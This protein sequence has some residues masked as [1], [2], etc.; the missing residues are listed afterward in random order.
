MKL[1][2]EV[3]NT[4]L[5]RENGLQKAEVESVRTSDGYP[6]SDY[7]ELVERVAEISFQNPEYVIFYRGQEDDFSEDSEGTTLYP[8]LFRAND[9]HLPRTE[10][11][12]RFEQLSEAEQ[13]LAE[14][15]LDRFS[16][17]RRV[18]TY[19]V[20]RRAIL[21]HYEVC[22]TSF[23]DVTR[24]L[25]V[26]CSMAYRD[27][28]TESAYVYLLGM[29]QVSGSISASSEHGVQVIRLLSVCPPEALRP[30]YQDGYVVG[31]FPTLGYREKLEYDRTEVDLSRR[32][33]GKFR[34]PGSDSFWDNDFNSIPE[35]YLFPNDRDDFFQFVS[36]ID[37]RVEDA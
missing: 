9:N 24:S 13:I 34:L 29:P 33:L 27:N 31:D 18:K 30:H 17:T 37:F 4:F 26:A 8:K 6:V 21:Q 23:L 28:D 15:Y 3:V 35:R 5:D 12:R 10:L 1:I 14:R 7:R 36:R 20:L 25:R 2:Q 32:L 16:G 19:D 11:Q 22:A